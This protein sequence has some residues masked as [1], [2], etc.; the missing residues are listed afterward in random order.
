[1]LAKVASN[2]CRQKRDRASCIKSA[3]NSRLTRRSLRSG[4][5]LVAFSQDHPAHPRLPTYGA[6]SPVDIYTAI[7]P[8]SGTDNSA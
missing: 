2:D 7:V 1:V 8:E 3:R 6:P 4:L 5:V